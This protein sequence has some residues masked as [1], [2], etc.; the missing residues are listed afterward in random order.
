M[1][2]RSYYPRSRSYRGS[3]PFGAGQGR[4]PTNYRGRSRQRVKSFDPRLLVNKASGRKAEE[5]VAQHRFSDFALCDQL[6]SNIQARGYVK[7]TPIQDQVIPH[8]VAGKD[9]IGIANTGTGKTAAFLIPLSNKVYHN[10]SQKVLIVTPTRE[11]ATQIEEEFRIFTKQMG[12]FSV[13][14]IGGAPIG[15]QIYQ[16]RKRP[17]FVIGTPGRLQDLEKRR[18]LHLGDYS[19]IVLDEVDRMFDMGFL[20][21]IKKIISFLPAV[22]QSLFFS[23]TLPDKIRQVANDFLQNPISVSIQ[24]GRPAD[25]IDQDIIRL[26]G[27]T[28]IEKLHKLL[29]QKGFDKVLV[30]GRTKRGIENLVRILQ[31]RGFQA[32][33]IHGNKS[34]SQ[35]YRALDQ[36]KRNAAQIMVATD[37]ASRGLD[38]DD[39]THVINYDLPDSYED[40]LHRIGRTGRIDKKGT[41]L[42]FVE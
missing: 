30:F 24:V 11:L 23:A 16:L 1:Q 7:P 15:R 4:G 17:Q 34:Q 8:L 25:N 9:V 10:R 29:I 2:P 21:E 28:K 3:K 41:A 18:L 39:V 38:I 14:C 26:N 31:D 19:S 6:K 5:Y 42:T 37:V 36:F 35:R 32:V 20:P 12:L 13:L 22:R 33:S 27:E 40:Y